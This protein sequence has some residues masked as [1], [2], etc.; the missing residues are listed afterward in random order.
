MVG[1]SLTTEVMESLESELSKE[2]G[3]D[4]LILEAKINNAI[5]EVIKARRYPASYS[6]DQINND[7]SNYYS[8]IRNIAL[9]DYNMSGAEYQQSHSENGISRSYVNRKE[10]F[11]GILPIARF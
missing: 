3:F 10:L 6:E 1:E 11:S 7:L 2:S 4:A 8:N 9:Y 5:K